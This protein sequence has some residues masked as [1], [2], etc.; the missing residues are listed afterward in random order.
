MPMN[1]GIVGC[2][3][4]VNPYLQACGESRWLNLVAC[5]D[6]V[7]DRAAAACAKTAE[8]GWGNPD[9]CS[10][11]EMLADRNV[12][13]VMNLTNPKAHFGLNIRALE[14]GK[15]VHAEKPLC[16]TR[17]EGRRLLDA[18]G[19]NNVRLGCAPDTFLG[20]GHQTARAL[21]D[22]GA[23]GEPASVTMFFAGGG[24]DGYHEDPEFF[25]QAGAGPLFDVGV[26][27]LTDV[28]NL[29]GPVQKV[30]AMAK[31]TFSERTVLSK[32]KYGQKFKVEV[33]THVSASL[34]FA[35]GVVGTFVTSF[36][37]KG[38]HHLPLIEIYGTEGTLC[39]PDPNGFGG[40]PAIFR[41]A[42]AGSG[43]Q[44]V[45]PTHGYGGTSRGIG[46]ADIAA[47]VAGERTHRA[48]GELAFHVLDVGL[49]MYESSDSG[50][51][52]E[53]ACKLER[54]PAFPEGVTADISD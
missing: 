18:A 46:A 36:D 53:V 44:E 14:A 51:A 4:I 30:S 2:G 24:P 47:A 25:F 28:I 23:I 17:E 10:Y 40:K 12:D 43:W 41:T 29:L 33:P 52:M 22:N 6:L 7:E 15:H 48:T 50:R 35:N 20:S 49:A 8:N 16:V 13:L 3:M 26:Y 1:V 31:T 54:P 45:E 34:E 11:E 19:K 32:K 39:V 38:G 37:I 5:A 21:I 42:E 9:V 27:C